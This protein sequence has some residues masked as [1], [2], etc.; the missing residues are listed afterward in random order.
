MNE[1]VIPVRNGIIT[2]RIEKSGEEFSIVGLS[3]EDVEL[4]QLM[5]YD[6]ST[7]SK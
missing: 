4:I 5:F 7:D 1:L 3:A 6:A 2:R